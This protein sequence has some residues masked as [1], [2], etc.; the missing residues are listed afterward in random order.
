MGIVASRDVCGWSGADGISEDDDILW[1]QTLVREEEIHDRFAVP[2]DALLGGEAGALAVSPVRHRVVRDS[3]G[4][5]PTLHVEERRERLGVAVEKERGCG[6][7]WGRGGDP[8]RRDLF[9]VACRDAELGDVFGRGR[10][11]SA[12]PRKDLEVLGEDEKRAHY[13]GRSK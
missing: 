3:V 4:S 10:G 9:P 11:G 2:I 1:C 7:G 8:P 13:H 5:E 12:H 6:L